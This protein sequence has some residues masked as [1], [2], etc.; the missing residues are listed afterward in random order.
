MADRSAARHWISKG[1]IRWGVTSS[2][3][4]I[5]AGRSTVA[6]VALPV[7]GRSGLGEKSASGSPASDAPLQSTAKTTITEQRVE[8]P[9]EQRGGIGGACQRVRGGSAPL[10]NIVHGPASP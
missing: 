7:G 9:E 6:V 1:G 8:E 10:A 2:G 3:A 4:R 5:G